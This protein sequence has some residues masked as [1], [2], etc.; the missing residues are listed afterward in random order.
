MFLEQDCAAPCVRYARIR[1]NII[2]R[3]RIETFEKA[4][5]F[6]HMHRLSF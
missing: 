5:A 2:E 4:V 1:S 3:L 6:K